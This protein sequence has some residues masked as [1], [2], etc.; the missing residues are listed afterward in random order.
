[1]ICHEDAVSWIS[2]CRDILKISDDMLYELSQKSN[3]QS[4]GVYMRCCDAE[5]LTEIKTHIN[6]YDKTRFKCVA[7]K[8]ENMFSHCFNFVVLNSGL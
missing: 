1:M 5:V 6:I 7:H 8:K 4:F 3:G 2:I